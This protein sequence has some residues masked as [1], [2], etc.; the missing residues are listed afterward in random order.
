M[1]LAKYF[2]VAD[3]VLLVLMF[4]LFYWVAIPSMMKSRAEA[5]EKQAVHSQK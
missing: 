3:A 5:I 1:K 4:C 2:S